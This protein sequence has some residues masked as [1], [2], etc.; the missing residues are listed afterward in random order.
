MLNIMTLTYFLR[1]RIFNCEYLDQR[2]SQTARDSRTIPTDFQSGV[3]KQDSLI[4][5]P[6]IFS[7]SAFISWSGKQVSSVF[8]QTVRLIRDI[9]RIMIQVL[10]VYK[11]FTARMA[12]ASNLVSAFQVENVSP[13]KT[14][15]T[16]NIPDNIQPIFM[17]FSPKLSRC[18]WSSNF[19]TECP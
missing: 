14:E 19:C 15:I 4:F 11:L 16:L 1:S 17:K 13:G 2:I 6:N 8:S 9:L 18:I 7:F 10:E 3:W 12:F 5:S